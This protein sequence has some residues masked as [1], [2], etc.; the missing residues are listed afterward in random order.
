MATSS[1]KP[2]TVA[3]VGGGV[4][5][6]TTGIL[7][8]LHG[9]KT[10]IYTEYLVNEMTAL[11]ATSFVPELASLYA[12]ASI[13][14]HFVNHPKSE[15]ILSI[16]QKFFHRLAFTAA[17]GVRVQRHYELYE[18]PIKV[19]DYPK[20][21]KDFQLLS[22]DGKS[23]EM[24]E[25]IPYRKG[26]AGIWGWY[27][28]AF[29]AEVP[30]YLQKIYEL[31][32]ASGGIF[33]QEKI[34]NVDE[35]FKL[36]ADILIN[37]MGRWAPEFFP[38]DKKNTRIMRGHMI[39]ANIFHVPHDKS[40]QYFSYNYTPDK[41]IYYQQ[42]NGKEKSS[43]GVYFYPRSDGWLLGG[44]GL[45]G[46]PEIGHDWRAED[47]QVAAEILQKPEW[48]FGVPKPMWD[49]NRELI[50]DITNIDIANPKYSSNT[51]IGYRFYRTPI[52]IEKGGNINGKLLLH[53]YGHGGAGY[54]LSWGSAYEMLSII[55]EEYGADIFKFKKRNVR[56]G[57]TLSLLSILEDLAEEEYYS[58]VV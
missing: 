8:N 18:S 38:D 35:F 26:A 1:D 19:P 50:L 21:I 31:Y 53:N 30:T 58:K 54:T 5:G 32:I 49:L 34:K 9:I 56:R 22:E 20:V 16:S 14:P 36:N 47:E 12:A 51:Y 39:K 11:D 45:S 17:C 33:I 44:S 7:L 42:E 57:F 3:I 29:F 43:A 48:Q 52:R 2:F 25:N 40:N 6:V 28:S 55:R 15:E 10:K 37:C 46:Y 23:Y 4:I 13:I 24:D 41:D 27:F